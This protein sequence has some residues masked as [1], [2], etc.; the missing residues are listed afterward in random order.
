[1]QFSNEIEEEI[2][3]NT[4]SRPIFNFFKYTTI[5]IGSTYLCNPFFNFSFKV[6]NI[7]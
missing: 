6:F 3:T 7:D 1:M 5:F 4:P 2:E